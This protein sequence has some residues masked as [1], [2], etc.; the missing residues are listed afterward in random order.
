MN[1]T[2]ESPEDRTESIFFTS[3]A[4]K[5]SK[6]SSVSDISNSN[7]N[8]MET[9]SQEKSLANSAEVMNDNFEEA[10]SDSDKMEELDDLL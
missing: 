6:N 7:S 10:D 2:K 8:S 5:Q 1:K 4:Y 9:D 3:K